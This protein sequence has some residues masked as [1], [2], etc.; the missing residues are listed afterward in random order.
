LTPVD[1]DTAEPP[2][3]IP[4]ETATPEAVLVQDEYVYLLRVVVPPTHPPVEPIAKIPLVLLPA[5]ELPREAILTAPTPEA[6]LE[7]QAYVYLFRV[8]EREEG[9][10][11]KVNI[12]L[13]LLPAVE[14]Q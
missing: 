10:T 11:P 3:E 1:H 4:L 9:A 14:P 2:V 12:P 5:P 7:Q 6:V 8:V 13:V